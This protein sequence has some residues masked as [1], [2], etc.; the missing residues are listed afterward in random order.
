MKNMK[1]DNASKHTLKTQMSIAK[2]LGVSVIGVASALSATLSV[3]GY[4]ADEYFFPDVCRDMSDTA[5][6]D[7]VPVGWLDP[8]KWWP[9]DKFKDDAIPLI[10]ITVKFPLYHSADY[11]PAAHKSTSGVWFADDHAAVNA[12]TYYA[13]VMKKGAQAPVQDP[14]NP[15]LFFDAEEGGF[16]DYTQQCTSNQPDA[17]SGILKCNMYCANGDKA[18][19]CDS[20]DAWP[21]VCLEAEKVG[22]WKALPSIAQDG[23]YFMCGTADAS[24]TKGMLMQYPYPKAVT[25]GTA[26][27]KSR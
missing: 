15:A 23:Y 4:G 18:G 13:D 14:S 3:S 21:T 22:A 27:F 10:A 26:L 20:R 25:T 1:N 7:T 8:N 6:A 11:D 16:G 12:I 9:E 24:T 17:T 19:I 2:L 5:L